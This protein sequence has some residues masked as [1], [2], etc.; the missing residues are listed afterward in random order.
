MPPKKELVLKLTSFRYRAKDVSEEQFHEYTSKDH[1]PKAARIQQRH[2]ALRVEQYHTPS[3]IRDLVKDKMPWIN[4]PGWSVDDH[5]VQISYW[6]RTLEQAHAILMD[7][8][9]QALVQEASG[10]QDDDRAT[11]AAGWVEVYVE[12]GKLVNMDEQGNTVY[13]ESFAAKCTLGSDSKRTE[14]P[15]G[16]NI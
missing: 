6:V 12:D 4:R 2:G 9:F 11:F 14:M 1:G 15:E 3:A 10:Y 8:E 7:P 16:Q 5:D 13:Q